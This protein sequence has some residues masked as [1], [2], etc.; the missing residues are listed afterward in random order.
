MKQRA[1]ATRASQIRNSLLHG[2][3][4]IECALIAALTLVM[5]T[6]CALNLYWFPAQ[7]AW[8]AGFGLFGMAGVVVLTVVDDARL[9][10]AV[11]YAGK[12][13]RRGR[14]VM[15][16]RSLLA[17][18]NA[19]FDAHR[20]LGA[21]PGYAGAFALAQKRQLDLWL[22]EACGL[23]HAL[24]HVVSDAHLIAL[25]G[26]NAHTSPLTRAVGRVAD[27][28]LDTPEAMR[29]AL[30]ATAVPKHAHKRLGQLLLAMRNADNALVDALMAAR[31]NPSQAELHKHLRRMQATQRMLRRNAGALGI[32]IGDMWIRDAVSARAVNGR[33][34]E[35][36]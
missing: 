31:A 10:Q 1:N 24:D 9:L 36:A 22:L 25:L 11:R 34:Q 35:P 2:L 20:M 7:L 27:L 4:S 14:I 15:H 13:A 17:Q 32:R 29:V 3:T 19:G 5:M 23:A 18:L 26:D 33:V 30:D 21:S 28:A 8:W 12:L 16:S 6:V